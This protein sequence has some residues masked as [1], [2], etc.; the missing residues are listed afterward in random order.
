[1]KYPTYF[2]NYTG[3][4]IQNNDPAKRGRVKIFIPHL[5]PTIYDGWNKINRD[6]SFKFVGININS[7]ISGIIE[8]LKVIVPWAEYAAPLVGENS[9]GRYNNGRKIGT[10]SDSSNV[11]TL[12]SDSCASNINPNNVTPYSQNLDNIGEKPG[13]KYDIDLYRV[14]DAYSDPSVTKTNR[15]NKYS[16]NYIPEVYSNSAKGSFAVPAV[17]SHVWVFFINGDPLYPVYFAAAYSNSDW[18][19]IYD[20]DSL[21]YPGDFENT[22]LSAAAHTT[23]DTDTYRNKYVVNQKGGTIQITNSDKRESIKFSHY[24]GSF[25]EFTNFVNIE[26]A[27]QNDQKLVNGDLF[28]TVKGTSNTF[29]YGESDSVIQGDSYIKVGSLDDTLFQKWYD[30]T[31]E[32]SNTKQLFDIKRANTV[33]RNGINLTSPNQTKAGSPA[34]CPVCVGNDTFYWKLNNTTGSVDFALCTS[35]GGGPYFPGTVDF[36]KIGTLSFASWGTFRQLGQIFGGTCPACGGTGISPSTVDG[37]WIKEPLKA[38]IGQLIASK[39]TQ[40]TEIERKMGTGGSQIIDITKH[41]FE[42]IGMVMNDSGSIRLDP[43]GKMQ[44]SDIIIHPGGVFVNRAATPLIEYVQVDDLPGGNYT[45]NVCNKY[46]VQVGAGGVSLKSFGPVNITGAITNIAGEQVNIASSNEVNIDG[47]NRLSIIA[48]IISIR[49]REKQQVLIDSSLGVN[50]NVVI[51]GGCHVEGELTINHITAPAEIQQT[52]DTV[53]TGRPAGISIAPGLAIGAKIGTAATTWTA[54]SYNPETQLDTPNGIPAYIGAPDPECIIGWVYP[55]T[56]LGTGNLGNP[57]NA[58]AP[59]PI[60]GSGIPSVRGTYFGDMGSPFS[61][62]RLYGTNPDDDSIIMAPH[63]HNFLN[64]P[65]TLTSN[66]DETRTRAQ[67]NNSSNRNAADP[68][69]N[70]K[71]SSVPPVAVPGLPTF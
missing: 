10:I 16:Y 47:G 43:I 11:D 59:I 37:N 49:Q 46:T 3:I 56:L 68:I 22:P 21:D 41:K 70:A 66:N 45:L 55:G 6:K 32:I 69:S 20:D 26:F 30:L 65:L 48:D 71:K 15:A 12:V 50:K 23:I 4:V 17:G 36:N 64:V 28:Q 8:D 19:S 58:S 40:L 33:I 29:V 31:R 42:T 44:P 63:S 35:E 5:S 51:G 18:K 38:N 27:S 13:N 52:E 67:S 53:V 1:M 9:S 39:A 24:S 60:F 14:N 61:G 7:D 2:G 57:V 54:F 34:P 62:V 25:K